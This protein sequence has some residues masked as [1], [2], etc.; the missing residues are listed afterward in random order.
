MCSIDAS[1]WLADHG[2][3]LYRYAFAR[4][5]SEA[6][7]EDLVQ[8]T[9]LA[10][11]Q[12]LQHFQQHAAVETWLIAILKHKV[13]DYWRKAAREAP[14]STDSAWDEDLLAYQF[15]QNGHWQIELIEWGT[16]E[17]SF[18]NQEFWQVFLQC[19]TRLP[20]LMAQLFMLRMDG[21]STDECCKILALNNSNHL[22]VTLSR[23]RMKLRQ[24]LE[25]HWFGQ[26]S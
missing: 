16:P 8:D 7:A 26:E 5:R 22:W 24:C 25:V 14:L 18:E 10:G 11:L 6:V 19:Q 4:V 12:N 1:N 21:V 17:R 15:D 2:D 20:E 23:A 9:L 3:T 13:I